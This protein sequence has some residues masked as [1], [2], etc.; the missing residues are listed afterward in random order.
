[1]LYS[2]VR[3][4]ILYINNNVDGYTVSDNKIQIIRYEEL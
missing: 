3:N 1:M 2:V 4:K